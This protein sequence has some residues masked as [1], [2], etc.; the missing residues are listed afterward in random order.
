MLAGFHLL[1]NG[2]QS[3]HVA[4]RRVRGAETACVSLLL[5]LVLVLALGFSAVLRV[6]ARRDK[7]ERSPTF[8]GQALAG[9]CVN[10]E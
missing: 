1:S 2:L 10:G 5:G 9:Y 6:R 7:N 8:P 3:R 4:T